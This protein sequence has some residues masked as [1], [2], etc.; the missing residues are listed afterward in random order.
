MRKL[1]LIF[2]FLL[3]GYLGYSQVDFGVKSGINIATTK[4]LITFP[5]NRIGFYGGAFSQIPISKKLF[6]QPELLFS[7]KGYR[8]VDLSDRKNVSMRLNYLNFPILLGY[9]IDSKTK[10]ILGIEPGLFL[11]AINYLNKNNFNA[12]NSFPIKFDIGTA[13]GVSYNI[14]KDIGTEIRYV[15]GFKKFYQTDEVGNRRA[16]GLASNRAFQIGLYYHIHK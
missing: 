16:E 7:S 8:Y 6:F 2:P 3:F 10:L 5:K 9:K 13:I 11:S 1:A 4:N 12:T 14:R 15:Y